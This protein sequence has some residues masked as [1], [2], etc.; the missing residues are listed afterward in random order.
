MGT[1]RSA[2]LRTEALCAP[3]QWFVLDCTGDGRAAAWLRADLTNEVDYLH[4]RPTAM[5]DDGEDSKHHP[6]D[7]VD[8]ALAGFPVQL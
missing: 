1:N 4:V 5:T 3:T 6:F 2:V 7:Q 8:V